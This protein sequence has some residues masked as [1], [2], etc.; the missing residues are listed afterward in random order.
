LQ[1]FALRAA[2]LRFSA[3]AVAKL[4]FCNSLFRDEPLKN[5]CFTA[6]GAK[7]RRGTSESNRFLEVPALYMI[8]MN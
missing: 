5:A 8:A 6:R 2:K 7:N 4:K 1:F 3:V